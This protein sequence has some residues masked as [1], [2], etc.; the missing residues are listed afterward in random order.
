MRR[1]V[2]EWGLVVSGAMFF[3][4]GL[5]WLDSFWLGSLQEPVW[6][7]PNCFLRADKGQVCIFSELGKNWKPTTD[8][9][10]NPLGSSVRRYSFWMVPGVEY[11][12]R[13]LASGESVW[14]LELAIVV[15]LTALFAM[16][17]AFWRA[18]RGRWRIGRSGV[19]PT[20]AA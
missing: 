6:L 11:H 19:P 10:N 2:T 8:G 7:G 5:V 17:L 1:A 18:G 20:P 13:L 16:M 4:L 9:R 3:A 12:N 15:P 14:S